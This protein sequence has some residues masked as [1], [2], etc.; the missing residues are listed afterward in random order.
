MKLNI[1]HTSD[2]H[3]GKKLFKLSRLE[4]QIQF[5]NFLE[6]KL[7]EKKCH[8]LLISGDIFDT[9][10]PPSDAIGIYLKFLYKM[11]GTH[12]I[13]IF[14]ISGNHDSGKFLETQRPFFESIGIYLKGHMDITKPADLVFSSSYKSRDSSTGR[15]LI[16]NYCIG[17]LPYFKTSDLLKIGKKLYPKILETYQNDQLDIKRTIL[18]VLDQLLKDIS[19]EMKKNGLK[20]LMAHH[21]FAGFEMTGSE[22]GL[23]LS[24]LDQ[25]PL[26]LVRDRFDYVALGHIHK[27][28]IIQQNSPAI[29]YS[30]SPIP[31]RFSEKEEKKLVHIQYCSESGL[32]FRPVKIPYFKKLISLECQYEDL[33]SQLSELKKSLASSQTDD[34]LFATIHYKDPTMGIPTLIKEELKDYPITLIGHQALYGEGKDHHLDKIQKDFTLHQ[35]SHLELFKQYYQKKHPE[36]QEIPLALLQDFNSNLA[37]YLELSRDKAEKGER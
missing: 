30:G 31:F 15:E 26:A 4:E 20:I 8:I 14:I 27:Y 11:A 18:N 17:M 7:L 19:K 10:Y 3:L 35:L 6:E 1:I 5:L 29:V 34:L 13:K 23:S 12:H 28:K 25:L 32:N 24:G 37:E 33:L 16:Q 9:P 2:W 22:Q 21:L 36:S